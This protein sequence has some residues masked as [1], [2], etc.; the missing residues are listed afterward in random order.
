MVGLPAEVQVFLRP[1]QI[2]CDV[3][4][5]QDGKPHY[6][7]YHEKQHRTL[8]VNRP[9]CIYGVD[10]RVITVPRYVQRYLRDVWREQNLHPFTVMWDDKF[11][12]DGLAGFELTG[13]AF[14]EYQ[15]IHDLSHRENTGK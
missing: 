2:S 7:E 12:R 15:I 10:G 9:T 6:I 5:V 14:Q 13:A 1:S 4:T 11:A 8:S 3:V